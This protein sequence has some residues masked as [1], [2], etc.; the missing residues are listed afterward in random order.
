M[1]AAPTTRNLRLGRILRLSGAPHEILATKLDEM[2]DRMVAKAARRY[3]THHRRTTLLL[4]ARSMAALQK[5][6][7]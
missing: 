1:D 4:D 3:F 6:S 7:R 5:I 2:A